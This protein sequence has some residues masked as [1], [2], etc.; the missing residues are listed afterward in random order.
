MGIAL[1]YRYERGKT[2]AGRSAKTKYVDFA[3]SYYGTGMTDSW[4]NRIS[5]D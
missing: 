3:I 5:G 2:R 1:E 4:L